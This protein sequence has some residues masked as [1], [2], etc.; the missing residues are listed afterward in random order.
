MEEGYVAVGGSDGLIDALLEDVRQLVVLAEAPQ[1]QRTPAPRAEVG[2]AAVE[3]LRVLQEEVHGHGDNHEGK[4]DK[5]DHT[6]HLEP[7]LQ[8]LLIISG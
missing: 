1:S 4:Q 3:L 2:L 6:N 7:P 5:V 8:T